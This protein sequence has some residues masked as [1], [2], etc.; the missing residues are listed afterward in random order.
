MYV[1]L[2]RKTIQ[3]LYKWYHTDG[4]HIQTFLFVLWNVY[5]FVGMNK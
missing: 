1:V 3:F 4:V 2:L 5:L